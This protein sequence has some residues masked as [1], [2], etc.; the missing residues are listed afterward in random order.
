M[1]RR[2]PKILCHPD[3]AVFC[4]WIS[5]QNVQ[6]VYIT[7]EAEPVSPS[8]LGVTSYDIDRLVWLPATIA[9][10]PPAPPAYVTQIEPYEDED[11]F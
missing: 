9:V 4:D 6:R 3:G 2:V 8:E 10:A 5:G 11:L 7:D 1:A